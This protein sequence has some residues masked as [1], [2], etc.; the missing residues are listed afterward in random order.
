MNRPLISVILPIFNIEE[1][2][3]KCMES[4][5]KQTYQNIEI[6][7][8]DDGSS[9]N[10]AHLCDELAGKDKRAIVYH[11]PN[12]GLSDA[13]NY[14]IERANGDYI[15][16][17]DP[18][19]YV[20]YDYI[21][22]LYSLVC[23]YDSK[24]SICQHRV[25]YD[26]G[27][28]KDYGA[29]GDE[30]ISTKKCLDRMLYHDVI[31]TSAWAKLYHKSLFEWIRYPKG[32]IFEDIGTTYA[33]MLECDQ[34][35]V[36]YES[37]YNYI[38]HENSIV[39]GKFKPNK[40]DMLLMT[41]KMSVDV[42]NRFPDLSD[43]ILRRRVYSRL[44]TLN[45]MLNTKECASEKKEIIKFIK[46]NRW[47]IL[48]NKKAPKRDKIAICLLSVSYSLYRFCWLRYQ[49][50]IMKKASAIVDEKGRK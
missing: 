8:V 38:F 26:N 36:G 11:K 39:T 16:C 13:R 28:V 15:T 37:K 10:C 2:L 18:D 45:Q 6:V 23:K 40:L 30:A 44:S 46:S 9:E 17:I 31:D 4:L 33:L 5:K 19:D 34:I 3:P 7:M 43:A 21:E 24:M 29:D 1:Y 20:D 35:A 14:G 22:Y 47:K 48:K 32:K 27:S 42:Q 41:D 49:A 25:R 12:G 50:R